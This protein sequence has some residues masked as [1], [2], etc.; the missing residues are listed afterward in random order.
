MKLIYIHQYFKF[1]DETGGTRS[2]DLASSFVKKGIDITVVMATIDEKYNNKQ[3]WTEIEIERINI[4]YIYLP[5]CNHMS[6]LMR[7]LV[8]FKFLWFTPFRL[9]KLKRDIV[10]ATSTL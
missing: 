9:L 7:S 5:Y 6:Y 3:R 1:P 10:L 4:H 8:F 2:Y